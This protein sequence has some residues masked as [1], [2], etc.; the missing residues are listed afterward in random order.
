MLFRSSEP[1]RLVEWLGHSE[2]DGI[3]TTHR[4]RDHWGAL[5]S[6]VR[7]TRARTY[8]HDLDADSIE[9]AID[10]LVGDG[11]F[12]EFGDGALE[13]LHVPGHTPGSIILC[14]REA[15]GSAHLFTGDTLFP[16]GVGAVNPPGTFQE[17]FSGVVSNIF[18]AFDDSTWVYPGHG[19]DTTLGAERPALGEWRERGW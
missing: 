9:L 6:M 19:F 7:S 17:L 3:I 4:H 13:V 15:S 11:D 18:D 8:A 10:A 5:E 1:N 2:L 16:G 14:L 12:I